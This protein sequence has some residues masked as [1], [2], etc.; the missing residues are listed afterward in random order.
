MAV[1][2]GITVTEPGTGFRNVE[3]G[4]SLFD[5]MRES[6][7]RPD[8]TW[9]TWGEAGVTSDLVRYNLPSTL[10]LREIGA[11]VC[12]PWPRMN[13]QI[14]LSEW[15]AFGDGI[16][17]WEE[18][19]GIASLGCLFYQQID[20]SLVSEN[21]LYMAYNAPPNPGFGIGLRRYALPFDWDYSNEGDGFTKVI[22][23]NGEFCLVIPYNGP[24]A[25]YDAALDYCCELPI[26][27]TTSSGAD[28][29]GLSLWIWHVGGALL[30]STD[31]Q[32]WHVYSRG[33][34]DE[35]AIDVDAGPIQVSHVGGGWMFSLWPLDYPCTATFESKVFDKGYAPSSALEGGGPGGEWCDMLANTWQGEPEPSIVIT[36]LSAEPG[37]CQYRADLEPSSYAIGST[38]FGHTPELYAVRLQNAPVCAIL[39]STDPPIFNPQHLLS[40]EI[41]DALDLE[42]NGA[43]LTLSNH[44]GEYE[45]YPAYAPITIALAG[46][47]GVLTSMWSGYTYNPAGMEG[48]GALT[49]KTLHLRSG[50]LPFQEV[51]CLDG[52]PVFAGR[53]VEEAIIWAC[54]RCGVE[55][56]DTLLAAEGTTVIPSGVLG[57]RTFQPAAGR[58]WWEFLKEVAA[59]DQ[60]YYRIVDAKLCYYKPRTGTP[61][62]TWA[63][64]DSRGYPGAPAGTIPML[65]QVE[66]DEDPSGHRTEVVC[67]GQ[68]VDG[69]VISAKQTDDAT[70]AIVGWDQ[71]MVVADPAWNTQGR[72]NL[73]CRAL[74][75]RVMLYP[76][77]DISFSIEG[78]P[79]LLPRAYCQLMGGKS[80]YDSLLCEVRRVVTRWNKATGPNSWQQDV[81]VRYVA[82][83]V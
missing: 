10:Y 66:V 80:N 33:K 34:S 79:S 24:M 37:L 40:I 35:D 39:E 59:L 14:P 58:N 41:E 20:T 53:T 77:R 32:S 38:F 4:W 48:A 27:G 65:H 76:P 75:N 3:R 81:T 18:R 47:D 60:G 15:V 57:E 69:A 51:G 30:L 49:T 13:D 52:E 16:D 26:R 63:F 43:T 17:S 21:G 55:Y 9:E 54:L 82:E 50:T 7:M 74:A 28:M 12:R 78:Q 2:Y 5:S 56:N 1:S 72:L 46:T 83:V 25:L 67:I 42:S 68:T 23:G 8:Y 6:A 73:V 61:V 71:T 62:A 11:L 45:D 70:R 36:D 44:G 22:W 29:A 31:S 64:A 19:E